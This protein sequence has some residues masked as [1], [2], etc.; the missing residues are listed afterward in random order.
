MN[1]YLLSSNIDDKHI[2]TCLEN[3]KAV[4][5]WMFVFR[6]TFILIMDEWT[7]HEISPLLHKVFPKGRFFVTLY[8]PAATNGWLEQ[9][10]W[11]FANNP[12]PWKG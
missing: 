11:D 12:Q 4:V 3:C 9:A 8:E 2:E 7:A 1:A 5:N 10:A 6:G